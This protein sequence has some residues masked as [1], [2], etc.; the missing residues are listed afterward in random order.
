MCK[1]HQD[2]DHQDVV[3]RDRHSDRPTEKRTDINAYR[4][5]L[6]L[7]WTQPKLTYMIYLELLD[8]YQIQTGIP[9]RTENK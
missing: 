8:I 3:D 4:A 5:P 2:L 1:N 6:Q 9:R 7:Y